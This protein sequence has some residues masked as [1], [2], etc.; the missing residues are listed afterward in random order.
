[1]PWCTYARDSNTLQGLC[2]SLGKGRAITLASE[3]Q[4]TAANRIASASVLRLL[5][6][7]APL[8]SWVAAAATIASAHASALVPSL[9]TSS[10]E[11]AAIQGV[12]AKL[13]QLH[14][15]SGRGKCGSAMAY[16]FSLAVRLRFHILE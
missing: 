5:P 16:T 7:A 12:T 2:Q 3:R 10:C 1:M 8:P 15:L 6:R 11:A 13:L 9:W 4:L 14:S